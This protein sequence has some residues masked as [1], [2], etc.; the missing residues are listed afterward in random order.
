MGFLE[1]KMYVIFVSFHLF[2][3]SGESS[4]L[5]KREFLV[6]CIFYDLKTHSVFKESEVHLY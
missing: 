2:A 5:S 3:C 4:Y 6:T 1:T